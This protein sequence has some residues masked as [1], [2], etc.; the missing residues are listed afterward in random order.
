MAEH[1]DA[2]HPGE[3]IGILLQKIIISAVKCT[4]NIFFEA[5]SG[6]NFVNFVGNFHDFNNFFADILGSSQKTSKA[7]KKVIHF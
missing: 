6:I 7:S 1:E 2:E 5:V 4:F 3:S